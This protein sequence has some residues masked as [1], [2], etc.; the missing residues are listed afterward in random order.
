MAARK[1]PVDAA[2]GIRAPHEVPWHAM[3][4]N[5]QV[6]KELDSNMEGLSTAEAERRLQM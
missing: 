4:D 1:A 3:G 2:V 6:L 5:G